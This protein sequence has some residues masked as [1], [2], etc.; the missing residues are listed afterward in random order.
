MN[1]Y[2]SFANHITERYLKDLETIEGNPNV[3]LSTLSNFENKLNDGLLIQ[4]NLYTARKILSIIRG[5]QRTITSA[6]KAITNL[7]V[8]SF[9]E[10]TEITNYLKLIYKTDELD[11]LHLFKLIE[12]S[13]FR[14][15]SINDTITCILYIPILKTNLY[16]YQKIYPMPNKRSKMIIPPARYRLVGAIE[17][18]WTNEQCSII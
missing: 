2:T 18:S 9:P 10:L 4:Y 6:F 5:I 7:K 13:K 1:S 17:E 12:I 8:L 11:D 16:I 14:V 3:S 15:I